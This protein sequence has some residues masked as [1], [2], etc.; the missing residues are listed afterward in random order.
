V[1]RS[2]VVL[3]AAATLVPMHAAAQL[4][5]DEPALVGPY[6]PQGMSVFLLEPDPG[7]N[8]GALVHWRHDSASLGLAYRA[9]LARDVTGALA[10]L[11]GVDVSGILAH[12]VEDADIRVLWWTGIGGGLGNNLTI[13]VPAGLMAGWRGIG[14]DNVFA[15]YAGAHVS[16]DMSTRD[17]G[18]V[19]SLRPSLDVGLDLTLVS[20]FLVRVGASLGE[21]SSLAAGLRL[22][23]GRAAR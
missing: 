1:R 12:S 17:N 15:P 23:G 7:D 8:L 11:A 20:G 16:L 3:I 19:V 13:S 4:S 22:P 18:G 21:H 10:G 14:D 2:L 5:W 9:G 6:A